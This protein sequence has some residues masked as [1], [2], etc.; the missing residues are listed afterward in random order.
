MISI[1][2]YLIN[3]YDTKSLELLKFED[4]IEG[5]FHLLALGIYQDE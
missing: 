1:R 3:E 2:K 4:D 5:L